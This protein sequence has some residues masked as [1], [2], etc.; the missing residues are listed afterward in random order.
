RADKARELERDLLDWLVRTT[1]PTTIL[2]GVH[3]EG[4]QAVTRYHNSVNADWK[5]HPD[6]I[7]GARSRNYV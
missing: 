3:L 1:R 6:R 2:P 7:L 5:F 4:P